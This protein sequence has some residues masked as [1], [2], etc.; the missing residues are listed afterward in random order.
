M[1]LRRFSS[2]E[3]TLALTAFLVIATGAVI[4][5]AGLPQWSQLGELRQR[6]VTAQTKL[7]R[8]Q[9]LATHKPTIE[10]TYS[11]YANFWS[12][13]PEEALRGAFLDELEQ[14]AAS[15][16]LQLNLKPR[17]SQRDGHVS[18]LGVEV[19]AD[20]TQENV[21]AFLDSLLKQPSLLEIDRLRLSSS[22]SKD[23]P[24]RASLIVNKI[25]VR[26]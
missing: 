13:Q 17:P 15:A 4:S 25:I 14:L 16:S 7:G 19:E 11:A 24:L 5:Q 22:S 6:S 10:Q 26:E 12:N 23:Y 3:R 9:E 20:G 8:L 18:R 21:L 1:G 2:R